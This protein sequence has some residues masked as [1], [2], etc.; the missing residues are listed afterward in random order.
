MKLTYSQKVT[1]RRRFRLTLK[2]MDDVYTGSEC[3][4]GAYYRGSVVCGVEI[5]E[6]IFIPSSYPVPTHFLNVGNLFNVPQVLE[7][8]L[9][10]TH[11]DIMELN[12]FEHVGYAF[13]GDKPNRDAILHFYL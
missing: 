3:Y 9:R 10:K 5:D 1:A 2:V 7:S 12:G 13:G 8:H 6:F 4:I 11:I